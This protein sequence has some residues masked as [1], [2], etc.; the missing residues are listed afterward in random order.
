M[1]ICAYTGVLIYIVSVVLAALARSY[2]LDNVIVPRLKVDLELERVAVRKRVSLRC[3]YWRRAH[4]LTVLEKARVSIG[5][6]ATSFM[7]KA[8]SSIAVLIH[9]LRSATLFPAHTRRPNP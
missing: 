9:T 4:L 3:S 1:I 5:A 7:S 8:Q 2:R 6:P